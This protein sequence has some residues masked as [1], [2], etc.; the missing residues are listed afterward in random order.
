MVVQDWVTN[1]QFWR[2]SE[3]GLPKHRPENKRV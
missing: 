1:V 2:I 3:E